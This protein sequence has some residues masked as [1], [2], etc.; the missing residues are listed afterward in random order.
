MGAESTLSGHERKASPLR[1]ISVSV[2]ATALLV[3]GCSAQSGPDVTGSPSASISSPA[4][5]TAPTAGETAEPFRL[6]G[7]VRIV[8]N[9]AAGGGADLAA[10]LLEEP[11]EAE[12][13]VDVQI[14]N[15]TESGGV[16][17]ANEVFNA[18]PD[19][20]TVGFLLLPRT[21][22]QQVLLDT[23]YQTREFTPIASVRRGLF[24]LIVRADSPYE[25]FQDFIEASKAKP[26]TVGTTGAG[27]ATDLQA[28]R[29]ADVSGANI[30]RVPF[31][32]GAPA[33]TAV[34]GGH[35]EAAVDALDAQD[36][37]GRDDLRVLVV[38]TDEPIEEAPDLPTMADSD[39]P[40]ADV[41]FYQV[42][43]GPP[44]MPESVR[45]GWEAAIN[46]VI[47]DP[48]VIEAYADAGF[49]MYFLD[50]ADLGALIGEQEGIVQEYK[51]LLGG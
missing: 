51:E 27:S 43:F 21:I 25:T 23:E 45:Q 3:A 6:E 47:S 28:A 30:T 50:A 9:Q 34:L 19:G 44:G 39:L 46:T 11:L 32:G 31:D 16:A 17:G 15:I 13:G 40:P 4:T 38:P 22:Q 49:S 42:F 48:A 41:S 20:L 8:V 14:E 36:F 7:T 1:R 29:L 35:V 12:L 24:G 10:R 26:I 37:A 5:S 2:A 33:R 18:D